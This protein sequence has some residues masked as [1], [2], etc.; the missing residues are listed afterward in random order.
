MGSKP[1]HTEKKVLAEVKHLFHVRVPSETPAEKFLLADRTVNPHRGE[2]LPT[3]AQKHQVSSLPLFITATK[4]GNLSVFVSRSLYGPHTVA[5]LYDF[6]NLLA[7][8]S[9]RII[10]NDRPELGRIG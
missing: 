9:L 8:D 2:Q 5:D 10:T 6:T 1:K 7:E 4:T 3:T